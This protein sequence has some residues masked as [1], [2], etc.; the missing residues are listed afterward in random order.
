MQSEKTTILFIDDDPALLAA[1]RRLLRRFQ[2]QWNME[3]FQRATEA[4]T[5]LETGPTDVIV[6][7]IR[8]PGMDGTELMQHVA[9]HFPGVIRFIL[10]GQAE[11]EKVL[12][13]TGTVHQYFTKPCNPNQ[14][15][16][17]I[18]LIIEKQ[19]QFADENL[20]QHL[21]RLAFVPVDSEKC[22]RLKHQL[23]IATDMSLVVRIIQ[24]DIGLSLKVRQLA[25]S[26]FFGK[27]LRGSSV[28]TVCRS[29][30]FKL[31]NAI[32]ET[33][34]TSSLI[35]LSDSDS[36]AQEIY[37]RLERQQ[38]LSSANAVDIADYLYALWG[39]TGKDNSIQES[40]LAIETLTS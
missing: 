27:P 24:S 13:L 19:K 37:R 1:L 8:M 17:A 4:V 5:F 36:V 40:S 29:F 14:L 2:K 12:Q 33:V 15:F 39:I 30:G 21:N 28:E 23:A 32:L 3:F 16:D 25:S 34:E 31:L 18:S 35:E 10:S 9:E 20:I 6:S 22:S 26:S 38:N 7:D 11:V